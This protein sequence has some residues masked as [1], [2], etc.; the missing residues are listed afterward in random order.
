MP[1]FV[2]EILS[3]VGLTLLL[4]VVASSWKALISPHPPT[5]GDWEFG[6]E[7]LVASIGVA[8][9]SLITEETEYTS[10]RLMIIIVVG[11]SLL[12]LVRFTKG[13]GYDAH[14]QLTWKATGVV[15]ALGFLGLGL[16]FLANEYP[17]VPNSWWRGLFG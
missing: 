1:E 4:S 17:E 3:V 5:P 2:S 7:L 11:A 10:T 14:G 6:I 9:A 8:F 12:A 15:S 16:T 13:W